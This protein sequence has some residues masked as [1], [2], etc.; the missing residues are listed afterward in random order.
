MQKHQFEVVV[1]GAGGAGL[2]A[3]LYAS[4]TASTAV[5]S[6]LYPSRSHT[7][8]AQG[9]IGA[10]LA[11]AGSDQGSDTVGGGRS[12]A[13]H[14]VVPGPPGGRPGERG[15][16]SQSGAGRVAPTLAGLGRRNRR[17]TI[18]LLPT[19]FAEREG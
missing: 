8:A 12:H 1:V 16:R 4:R 5:I 6:K 15:R 14:G 7:G 3:A 13:G 18:A 11:S 9:G 2:T 17:R 19:A 10:A